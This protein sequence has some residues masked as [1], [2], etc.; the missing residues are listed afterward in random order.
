ME[1]NAEAHGG[2]AV[3]NRWTDIDPS[4]YDGARE[5]DGF[6][7]EPGCFISPH[8]VPDGVRLL[9]PH[10][11]SY[12][13]QLR[14][15]TDQEP[16]E[17]SETE[18][19]EIHFGLG[20]NSDRLISV[21]VAA[22]KGFPGWEEVESLLSKLISQRDHINHFVARSVLREWWSRLAEQVRELQTA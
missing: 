14:Y 17:F 21:K 3:S 18:L 9:G 1:K 16:I 15:L 12:V 4:K 22:T 5:V 8:D 19:P 20:R 13:I 10:Q 11:Q 7:L 2:G 6:M